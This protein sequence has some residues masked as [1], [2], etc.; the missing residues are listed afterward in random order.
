MLF[1][2]FCLLTFVQCVAGM[3]LSTL[4]SDFINDPGGGALAQKFGLILKP[5][6]EAI[7]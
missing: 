6:I 3:I 7:H 2:S 4:C 5:V 1:W